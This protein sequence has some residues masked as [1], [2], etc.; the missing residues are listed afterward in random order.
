MQRGELASQSA[1]AV[2]PAEAAVLRCDSALQ[3]K[4]LQVVLLLPP[5]CLPSP[6]QL[7]RGAMALGSSK[8]TGQGLSPLPRATSD[9]A[10]SFCRAQQLLLMPRAVYS[11]V[12]RLTTSCSICLAAGLG[13]LFSVADRLSGARTLVPVQ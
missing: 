9:A 7:G 2:L 5:G 6:C 11:R 1:V 13:V 4:Q 3:Q 10:F 8:G 12:A